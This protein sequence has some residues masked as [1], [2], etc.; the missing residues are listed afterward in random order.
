MGEYF[1]P[2][3]QKQIE[4]THKYV[5]PILKANLP[6]IAVCQTEG[7]AGVLQSKLDKQ[8]SIDLLLIKPDET[9]R[10]AAARIQETEVFWDTFTIRLLRQDTGAETEWAKLQKN[11][12]DNNQLSYAA[13]NR[14][15][16]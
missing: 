6:I 9:F 3:N 14:T 2:D 1:K 10:T 8:Y 13:I 5:K 16:Q 4:L 15:K 11:I 12:E 7:Q